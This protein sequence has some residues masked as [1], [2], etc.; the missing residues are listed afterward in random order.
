MIRGPACQCCHHCVLKIEPG[1]NAWFLLQNSERC[2]EHAEVMKKIIRVSTP[3][4]SHAHMQP[5]EIPAT[6]GEAAWPIKIDSAEETVAV[7][8]SWAVFNESVQTS[9]RYN[10]MYLLEKLC[11]NVEMN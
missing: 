7:S 8:Y 5:A 11:C 2:P 4:I 6:A 10:K 1:A 9:N 3:N